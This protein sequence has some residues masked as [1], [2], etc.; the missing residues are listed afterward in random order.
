VD[1]PFNKLKGEIRYINMGKTIGYMITFT[2]YG[3]WLQ[4]DKRGYINGG[5]ELEPNHL[6]EEA[7]KKLLTKEPVILTK[8]QRKMVE[9]AIYAKAEELD[10]KI[11][12]LSVCSNHTHIVI[13]YTTTD[14]GLISRYYKMAGQTA[15]HNSGFKGRLWAK[16][17]DKRFCF[18]YKSLKRRIKYVN[19]H[20]DPRN[21]LRGKI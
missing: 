14:L 20:N 8:I 19:A 6:L 1:D 11:L 5:E 18:D 21:K 17:F 12:S 3:S 4:G 7:N 13:D 2:T 9:D 16:G 10:Q 15:L